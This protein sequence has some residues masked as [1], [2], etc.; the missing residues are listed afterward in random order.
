MRFRSGEKATLTTQLSWPF[1]VAICLPVAASQRRAVL[2]DEA[3]TTREPS[4]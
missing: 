3:V 2:S 1:K 4:G